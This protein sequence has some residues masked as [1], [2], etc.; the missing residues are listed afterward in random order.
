MGQ[1]RSGR[2]AVAQ[3]NTHS[4]PPAPTA[5]LESSG[6][7][8]PPGQRPRAG[9]AAR[10]AIRNAAP[11]A[12]RAG[13]ERSPPQH[14]THNF[15]AEGPPPPP[16]AEPSRSPQRSPRRGR[17]HGHRPAD[18]PSH[19]AATHGGRAEAAARAPAARRQRREGR[20]AWPRRQ[21]RGAGMAAARRALPVRAGRGERGG[22]ERRPWLH[23][24]P[25]AARR[26]LGVGLRRHASLCLCSC[27]APSGFKAAEGSEVFPRAWT[28][29]SFVSCEINYEGCRKQSKG[30]TIFNTFQ[31]SC[32]IL[33]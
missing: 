14:G 1:S 21:P 15:P 2:A 13:N 9:S 26:R 33:T 7:L 29:L 22:P 12:T 5:E 18:R 31:F 16:R 23:G 25:G 10:A 32:V 28:N 17:G 4:A 11:R 19:A 8:R 27:F 30:T 6:T 3:G 24:P 20:A